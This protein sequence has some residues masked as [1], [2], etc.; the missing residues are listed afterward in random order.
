MAITLYNT[1]TGRKEPLKPKETNRVTMYVCGITAYDY[2][3]IGHARSVLAFDMIYRYLQYRGFLVTYIRNFTDIDDKI[4]KRANELG[5]SSEELAAR[6]IQAFHE[7]MARLQVAPP[8]MEP[9][10]TEHVAEIIDFITDLVDKGY[11]YQ[12]GNDVSFG[13]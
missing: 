1:L 2:C 8:T 10:A 5:T 3:H 4:I 6:F 13:L 7:D 12:V 9:R 11:A